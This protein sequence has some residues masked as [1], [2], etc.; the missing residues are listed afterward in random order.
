MISLTTV[1]ED[2][3]IDGHFCA[4]KPSVD[5]FHQ[6]PLEIASEAGRPLGLAQNSTA[7]TFDTTNV[8]LDKEIIVPTDKR[9]TS[10]QKD[11]HTITAKLSPKRFL[12]TFVTPSFVF[13]KKKKKHP[14]HKMSS[15]K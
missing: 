3:D 8:L 1:G 12:H 6:M 9:Q 2:S 10:S 15:F 13:L 7:V 4:F 14:H 11:C 5:E